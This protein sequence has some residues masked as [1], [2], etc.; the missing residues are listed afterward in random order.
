[1]IK[2]FNWVVQTAGSMTGN[3]FRAVVASSSIAT[4][5][6]IG[7]AMAGGNS[8]DLAAA[9]LAKG[10]F[11]SE[12]EVAAPVAPA[13]VAPA[14]PAGPVGGGGPVSGVPVASGTPTPVRT[15]APV[16]TSDD[17]IDREPSRVKHVFIL[18]LAS[19]GYEKSFG[20]STEMPYLANTLRPQ[21]QLLS[22][23]TLLANT[24]V[25]NGVAAVSGQQPNALTSANCTTYTP[26]PVSASINKLGF[27]PGNGCFYNLDVLTIIDQ[28]SVEDIKWR[29][30][31]EDMGKPEPQADPPAAYMPRFPK[32]CVVPAHGKVDS[33]Q[34]SRPGN[35]YAV[36]QNPFVYFNSLVTLG[37]C[38]ENDVPLENLSTDLATL[39]ATPNYVYISPNLCRSGAED[40]CLDQSSEPGGPE[41]ADGFL[42]EWVPKILA[43][44]AYRNDGALIITFGSATSSD[45][46][47]KRVGALVISKFLTPGEELTENYGP[48]SLL[49]TTQDLFGLDYLA[50]SSR[51]ASF[52]SELIGPPA[53][54][55]P[56]KKK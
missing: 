29:A 3:R 33:T 4:A 34:Q 16:D 13:P 38:Q 8:L 35:G 21:G 44:P 40:P 42:E 43:S 41:S 46:L 32:N 28:L 39:N 6:I 26:F 31:M 2:P 19:P 9:L 50:A 56:K 15:P 20:P 45:P 24:A 49:R 53:K 27:A 10:I 22:N 52:S 51:A 7:S 17:E 54:K 30:Y 1:V 12:P 18:S 14:G 37:K 5:A 55:K 23:Y 11:G 48:Y 47:A 25:P 36:R